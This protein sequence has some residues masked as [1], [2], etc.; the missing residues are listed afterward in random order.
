M[1][2]EVVLFVLVLHLSL[3]SAGEHA[4]QGRI[5]APAQVYAAAVPAPPNHLQSQS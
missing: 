1:N 2:A 4:R 5:D 3:P